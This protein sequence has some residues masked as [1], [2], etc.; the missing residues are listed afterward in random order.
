MPTRMTYRTWR[1]RPS[2]FS[3]SQLRQL[4]LL[5]KASGLGLTYRKIKNQFRKSSKQD[6]PRLL[7]RS[8][9]GDRRNAVSAD[10]RSPVGSVRTA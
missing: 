3:E 6:C 9:L 1:L 8:R 5:R 4:D 2:R 10:P 7:P